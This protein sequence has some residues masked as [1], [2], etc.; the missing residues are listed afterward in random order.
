MANHLIG[1]S[2]TLGRKTSWTI[3]FEL[4]VEGSDATIV[5]Q[6]PPILEFLHILS[7]PCNQTKVEAAFLIL[8]ARL[9]VSYIKPKNHKQTTCWCHSEIIK[10]KNKGKRNWGNKLKGNVELVR[11][12]P[13]F[14]PFLVFLILFLFTPCKDWFRC[15]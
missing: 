6:A 8:I 7:E 12:S 13:W 4:D 14:S 10:D 5:Q 1:Q 2:F 11:N 15:K 9:F 3:S